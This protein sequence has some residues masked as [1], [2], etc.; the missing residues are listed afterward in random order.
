MTI[1]SEVIIIAT[2]ETGVII[3]KEPTH[4]EGK[5]WGV[6]IESINK[7]DNYTDNDLKIANNE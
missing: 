7:T 1:G 5:I 4:P 6:Y 2:N 3:I